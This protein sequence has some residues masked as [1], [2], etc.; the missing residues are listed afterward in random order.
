M[1]IPRLL[2]VGGGAIGGVTAA[3]LARAG[4]DVVV[5][6]AN[7]EHV[8]CMRAPGLTLDELDSRSTVTINAVADSA[9]L[10]GRFTTALVTVK[11]PYLEAALAPLVER[12]LIDTYVSLG[13]G[14]VQDRIQRLTGVGRLMV[15]TVEW[16]AT[17][18]GPGHVAQ[19]TVAP[20]VLGEAEG[21][22]RPRTRALAH[23]LSDVAEVRV[24]DDIGGQVW[25]KLLVNSTFSGL[26]AVTGLLYGDI[27]A[28]PLGRR[29]ALAVWDEGFRV[30]NACGIALDEV[31]GIHPRELVVRAAEDVPRAERGL[32]VIMNS[33]A[34]TKASMLQDLERGVP[35]EV[36]VI[37]GGVVAQ[38]VRAGVPTPLNARI[39]QL[40]QDCERGLG[41]P[42]RGNL[43]AFEA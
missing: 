43:A 28:D 37:N 29:V 3:K 35:T 36:T 12:D 1:A 21:P 4:H 5:L 8:A 41:V 20:I 18:L 23:V 32:A 15:G 33:A 10:A 14:L 7:P 22:V 9:N 19:T 24:T 39:A 27:V 40:V 13:N 25:S 42:N 34:A 2:V 26:G 30:A 17:N 38:G 11:A 31:L 6:D 16:G